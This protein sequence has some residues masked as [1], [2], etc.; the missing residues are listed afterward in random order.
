[1]ILKEDLWEMKY[2][3]FQTKALRYIIPVW[4]RK[5][6][7]I[8]AYLVCGDSNTNAQIFDRGFIPI[9]GPHRN[10]LEK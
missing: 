10:Y 3:N 5:K 9:I 4:K 1:M 6:K 8:K 7:Q 2:I